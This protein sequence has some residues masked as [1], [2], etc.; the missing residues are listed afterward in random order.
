MWI[1]SAKSEITPVPRRERKDAGLDVL[2]ELPKYDNI[3]ILTNT[4]TNYYRQV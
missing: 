3:K 1:Q 4:G 2:H